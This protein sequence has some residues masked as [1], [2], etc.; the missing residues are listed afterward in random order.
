MIELEDVW[1]V[2]GTDELAIL[3]E[4]CRTDPNEALLK[5]LHAV[6]GVAGASLSVRKGELICLMGLSGSGKSTLVRLVNRLLEPNAG[7][8]RIDGKDILRFGSKAL[9]ELRSRRI[10]MVFQSHALIEHLSI[11]DNIALPLEILG[12]ARTKREDRADELLARV[13]LSGFGDGRISALS[14]GMQQRVGL[15]RALAADPDI[16][17]MDEPFSALDPLIRHDLQTQFMVLSKDLN[18]TTIFVTHDVDEAF[19]IADRVVLMRTGRIVQT[20]T[21]EELISNPVDSYVERFI[22]NT[23]L[24]IPKDTTAARA[25]A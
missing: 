4:V 21:P 23:R 3:R 12:V 22:G 25:L 13:G 9:R 5:R 7:R 15:A 8:V 10:G 18:K 19:R 11:R 1:K 6:I 20:G 2:F 24:R 17:L 14:G 16:L